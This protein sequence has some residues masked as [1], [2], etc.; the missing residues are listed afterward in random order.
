MAP[1]VL[2]LLLGLWMEELALVGLRSASLLGVVCLGSAALA[3][4]A[5]YRGVRDTTNTA[6]ALAA[7]GRARRRAVILEAIGR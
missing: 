4:V 3:L 5:Y 7:L 1:A 2:F 6:S